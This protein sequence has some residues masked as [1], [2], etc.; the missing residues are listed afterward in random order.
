MDVITYACYNPDPR[1]A[2]VLVIKAA[3]LLLSQHQIPMA[4]LLLLFSFL[5]SL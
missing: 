1:L 4:D 2:N 3:D 5:F